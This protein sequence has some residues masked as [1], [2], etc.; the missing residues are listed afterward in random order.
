MFALSRLHKKLSPFSFWRAVA[1]CPQ[2]KSALFYLVKYITKNKAD[3]EQVLVVLSAALREINA[4]PSVADDTGTRKRTAQHFV[5]RAVNN[6][7]GM[8]E[9][10]D[11]Q[12]AFMLLGGQAEMMTMPTGFLY[13]WA[14]VAHASVVSSEA[15]EGS[16]AGGDDSGEEED[17]A[18][19][20]FEGDED[21]EFAEATGCARCCTPFLSYPAP[22]CQ[23]GCSFRSAPWPQAY[24]VLLLS[25]DG[26]AA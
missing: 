21:E 25:T 17:D 24:R 15:L 22:T 5:T 2:A 23:G 6:I 11:P 18:H 4:N 19:P 3:L 20:C 13:V 1:T 8:H 9:L 16:D 14:A 7:T 26:P 10:A 12:V